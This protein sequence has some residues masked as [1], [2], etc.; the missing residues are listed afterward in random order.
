MEAAKWTVGVLT[1][2]VG[3][4]SRWQVGQAASCRFQVWKTGGG[5][6]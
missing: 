2:L 4:D 3:A 6:V 5:K 1:A